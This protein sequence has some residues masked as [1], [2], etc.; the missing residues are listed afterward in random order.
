MGLRSHLALYLLSQDFKE[1]HILAFASAQGEQW[2]QNLL[3]ALGGTLLGLPLLGCL[4]SGV[5]RLDGSA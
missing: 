4:C 1:I 5:M 3:C 2:K